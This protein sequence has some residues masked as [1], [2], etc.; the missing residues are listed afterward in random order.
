MRMKK[1]I[2]NLATSPPEGF[3][4][5][6][7][8][9][10]LDL[11]QASMIGSDDTPYAGGVFK[12]EIRI[13]DRYPFEPPIVTFLTPVYH[14]NID[15]GGRICLDILK[16]KPKGSWRPSINIST[17]LT[18]VQLLLAEPNPDDGLMVDVASEYK[19]DKAAFLR[20]ARD[21]TKKYAMQDKSCT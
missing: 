5:W 12:L 13:P 6:P 7:V 2:E 9:D 3:S 17:V 1:E 8:D 18:S 15:K 10:S 14:P 16:M 11:L 4:C 20:T 19:Y 21:H